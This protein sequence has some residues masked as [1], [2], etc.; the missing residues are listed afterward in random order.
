M[1]MILKNFSFFR[2]KCIL[3]LSKTKIALSH[4]FTIT[5]KHFCFFQLILLNIW[6][7]YIPKSY[8]NLFNYHV[9][10]PVYSKPENTKK[11]KLKK[12]IETKTRLWE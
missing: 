6:I 2:N 8:L 11:I 1:S 5:E 10:C 12:N 9:V 4:I 3:F 7:K